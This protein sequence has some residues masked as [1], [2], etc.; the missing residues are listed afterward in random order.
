MYTEYRENT[1]KIH[2]LF[3][4]YTIY[5]NIGI[6][7]TEYRE[8]TLAAIRQDGGHLERAAAPL[9]ADK[10]VPPMEQGPSTPTPEI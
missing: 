3:I 5:Y 8:V 7:N 1:Y 6:D 4:R 2:M 10:E 9:L